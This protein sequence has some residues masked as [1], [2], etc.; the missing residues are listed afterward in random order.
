MAKV[1]KIC[2]QCGATHPTNKIVC[3]YCGTALPP[4]DKK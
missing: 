1:G 3:V 4:V 2:S